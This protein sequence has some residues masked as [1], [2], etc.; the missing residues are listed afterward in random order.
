MEIENR[1]KLNDNREEL[2]EN[3]ELV[4]ETNK[5]KNQIDVPYYTGGS[6]STTKSNSGMS[7]F[8]FNKQRGLPY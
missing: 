2:N 6:S 1:K 3:N 4:N 7:M 8:E 5:T